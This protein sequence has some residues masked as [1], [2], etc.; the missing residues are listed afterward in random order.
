MV[1][2]KQCSF[3]S[4]INKDMYGILYRQ[5]ELNQM[6]NQYYISMLIYYP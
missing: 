2:V 5:K 1:A 6:T 4:T 3:C